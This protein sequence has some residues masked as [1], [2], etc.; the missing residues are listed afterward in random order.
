MQLL[1]KR[2]KIFMLEKDGKN[3]RFSSGPGG[4][5]P[6]PAW[7]AE[8]GTYNHG[9]EDGSIVNLT[10]K[11]RQQEEVL[12]KEEHRKPE[13]IIDPVVPEDEQGD[14][15]AQRAPQGTV[16]ASTTVKTAQPKLVKANKE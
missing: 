14:E 4:P 5:V 9:M 2:A 10:E 15:P 13:A 12:A 1:F 7:V 6:V 8:T 11:A 3:L 16:T